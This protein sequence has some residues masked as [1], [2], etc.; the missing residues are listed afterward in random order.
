M[1]IGN[2]VICRPAGGLNGSQPRLIFLH[3]CLKQHVT[4]HQPE[5]RPNRS[6]KRRRNTCPPE[7]KPPPDRLLGLFG[8]NKGMYKKL[9]ETETDKQVHRRRTSNFRLVQSDMMSRQKDQS[10]LTSFN[11]MAPEHQ[12]FGVGD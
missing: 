10:R 6:V 2:V 5:V 9:G 7:V 8:G 3:P 1:G 11:L 12:H 4:L